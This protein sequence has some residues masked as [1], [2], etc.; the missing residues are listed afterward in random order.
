MAG[1]PLDK[2]RAFNPSRIG[3]CGV[4]RA[5]ERLKEVDPKAVKLLDDACAR[6]VT[7]IGHGAI[8]K[9]LAGDYDIK[10]DDHVVGRHRK[11]QCSC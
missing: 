11:G 2:V 10:I 9:W 7:D 6:P 3:R 4:Y 1:D 5:R 8:Q